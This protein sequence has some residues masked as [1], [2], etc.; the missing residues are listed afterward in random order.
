MT[1]HPT[2]G[3]GWAT[4]FGNL[5]RKEW[6]SWWGTRRWAVHL[7]LW[8]LIETGFVLMISLEQRH[9]TTAARGLSE[10]LQIFF[11]AGGFFALIGAVLVSQGAVVGERQGGT[12]AW[13]LTKPTTRPAFL[14]S[15]FVAITS[16]FLLLSL[17]I[18]ALGVLLVFQGVWHTQ[19]VAPHFWEALAIQALHQT[20]YIA[21]TLML[22]TFFD[23]R[24]PVGGLALGFWIAGNIVPN[25]VPQWVT[26]ATP[27]PLQRAAAAVAE[28]Q[29]VGFPIWVPAAATAGAAVLALALGIWRFNREEF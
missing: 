21:F 17:L 11:Q 16:T 7:L 20:F 24:G 4:G 10:G 13:V 12:A 23:S 29:P 5:L 26:L 18:P 22:G 25:F 19:P 8:L 6:R 9:E 14:L 2:T 15:K 28:W 1:L 27:W 3:S